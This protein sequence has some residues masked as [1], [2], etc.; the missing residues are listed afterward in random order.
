VSRGFDAKRD[1]SLKPPLPDRQATEYSCFQ[2]GCNAHA[3]NELP[4]RL[5]ERQ[6]RRST[7]A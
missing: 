7:I 5:L 2:F 6:R 3:I 4:D 1:N